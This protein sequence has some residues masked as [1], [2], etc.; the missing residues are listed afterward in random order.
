[1]M[2]H[3]ALSILRLGIVGGVLVALIA[4]TSRKGS[5]ISGILP[6]FPALAV[7]SLRIVGEKAR[8]SVF[9]E[10]SIAA[11]KTVPPH[12]LFLVTS[13]ICSTRPGFRLSL[14]AGVAVWIA[15]AALIFVLPPAFR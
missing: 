14:L 11:M 6:L 4:W 15:S 10:T 5:V 2:G 7:L 12:V 13:F 8:P 9:L 1:M 3:T